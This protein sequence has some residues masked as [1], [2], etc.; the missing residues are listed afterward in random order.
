MSFCLKE[1]LPFGKL[2]WAS[3][4]VEYEG[5]DGGLAA[6][7]LRQFRWLDVLYEGTTFIDKV[8]PPSDSP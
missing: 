6:R 4:E 1:R 2:A 7:I 5:A 8:S 3:L